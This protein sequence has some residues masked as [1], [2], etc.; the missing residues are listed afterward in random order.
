MR[1][2]L[3]A[4]CIL[5]S[6]VWADVPRGE[7]LFAV[8]G[9]WALAA[10]AR[11]ETAIGL[12]IANR[13]SGT[14]RLT[15]AASPV[16]AHAVLRNFTTRHGLKVVDMGDYIDIA[17]RSRVKLVPGATEILLQDLTADLTAGMEIPLELTFADGQVLRVRVTL[18]Q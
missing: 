5:A 17:P 4:F 11:S 10:P 14:L 2:M 18:R 6:P 9:A 8:E 7:P 15:G 12:T 13:T 16:A 3:L 1:R